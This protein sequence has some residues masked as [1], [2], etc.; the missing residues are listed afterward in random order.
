MV[1]IP[2]QFQGD[3][4]GALRFILS[5]IENAPGIDIVLQNAP[6]PVGAGL[7]ASA[8]MRIVEATDAIRY[9]KEEAL[10]S[11]PRITELRDSA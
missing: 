7:D 10:P 6:N 8:L 11:G 2:K 1:L 3:G 4:D 9:V 5:V